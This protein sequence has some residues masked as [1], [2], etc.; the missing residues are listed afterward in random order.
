MLVAAVPCLVLVAVAIG[1]TW[2]FGLSVKTVT[3][4]SMSPLLIPGSR[5]V[6]QQKGYDLESNDIVV[7]H[8]R[9]TGGVTTHVFGGYASDG[10]LLTRGI[11]N[12]QPDAFQPAPTKEDVIGK[13]IYQTDALTLRP[14]LT[15]RGLG[16]GLLVL[17]ECFLVILLWK[18]GRKVEI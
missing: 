15:F 3:S 1:A 12:T 2:F 18:E 17:A 8:N 5:V 6:V 7:F 14:W 9:D 4:G 13:V 11:A 16:I 10:T